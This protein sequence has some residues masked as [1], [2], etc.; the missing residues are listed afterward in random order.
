MVDD[1][2][3][4]MK[5]LPANTNKQVDDGWRQRE[6]KLAADLENLTF[7]YLQLSDGKRSNLNF[8]LLCNGKTLFANMMKTYACG[9]SYSQ[10]QLL[11]LHPQIVVQTTFCVLCAKF[12][13]LIRQLNATVSEADLTV[14]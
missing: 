11:T 7:E 1:W 6:D 4:A 12:A 3:S 13:C 10:Q 2:L 8:W 5:R 14:F 9:R